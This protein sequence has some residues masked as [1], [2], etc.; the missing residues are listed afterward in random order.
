MAP[1]RDVAILIVDDDAV[2]RNVVRRLLDRLGFRR[3]EEAA[4]G[5]EALTMLRRNRPGLVI[6]DWN[7]EPMDGLDLLREIRADA[8]LAAIPVILATADT[9]PGKAAEAAKAG[10]SG[11]LEKPFD[12]R[13]LGAALEK[14]LGRF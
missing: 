4:D 8:A 6:S 9:G 10:A 5:L 7:M 2:M 12:G 3:V 11:Y 1:E 14:V 13:A